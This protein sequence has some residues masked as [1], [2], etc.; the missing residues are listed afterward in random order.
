MTPPDD[1]RVL[2]AGTTM[3]EAKTHVA[4]QPVASI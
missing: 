4:I 2:R 3:Q 1:G